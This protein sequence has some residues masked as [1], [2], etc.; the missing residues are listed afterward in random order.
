MGQEKSTETERH[1]WADARIVYR[2]GMLAVILAAMVFGWRRQEA[3]EDLRE[4]MAT[5]EKE[6]VTLRSETERVEEVLAML[7]AEASAEST[8]FQN[9]A[10]RVANLTR[11]SANRDFQETHDRWN[12][13]PEGESPWDPASPYVWVG[14]DLLHHFPFRSFDSHG[15]LAS[16]TAAILAIEPEQLEKLNRRVQILTEEFRH[17]EAANAKRIEEA[18][19]ESSA[20]TRPALTVRLE[21]PSDAF[22]DLRWRFQETLSG[23]L[24]TQR[25]ELLVRLAQNGEAFPLGQPAPSDRTFTV[26]REPDGR[27]G[28][29]IQSE[30]VTQS[31]GGSESL[32]PYVPKHLRA[33]FAPILDLPVE[34]GEG[35]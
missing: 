12:L 22:E 27:F 25:A 16:D 4:S 14:K 19:F 3:I 33:V 30:F 10:A 2:A 1:P 23:T 32:E 31:V 29:T 8:E 11:Q 35:P 13:P 15:H 6:E 24:G 7:R 18:G 5:M 9:L 34:E 17:I 28:L 21:F 20:D 26:T